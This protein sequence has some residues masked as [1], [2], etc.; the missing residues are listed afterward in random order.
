MQEGYHEKE[1]SCFDFPAHSMFILEVF[2][3]SLG[4]S[5]FGNSSLAANNNRSRLPI[6]QKIIIILDPFLTT[7]IRRNLH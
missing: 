2:W 5:I 1:Y 4:A 6:I 7:M 3:G